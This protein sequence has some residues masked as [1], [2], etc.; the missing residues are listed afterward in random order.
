MAYY[1]I[2]DYDPNKRAIINPRQYGLKGPVPARGVLCC[3][4]DIIA[5]FVEKKALRKI[6][7]FRSELMLHPVYVMKHRG[8]DLFVMHPGVGAPLAAGLFEEILC[9]GVKHV[10]VCGGCGV[11]KPEIAAGYTV[12]VTNAIRDEGTS[13]HYLPPGKAVSAT[14]S[15]VKVLE[16]T[17]KEL[18]IPYIEGTSWTTDGF[19]RETNVRRE[20]RIREGC[21]VVEMEAAA[22]FAVAKFRK[23]KIGQIVYGG[24]VVIPKGW[25]VRDW[26]KRGDVR[27]GLF[28]VAVEACS[29]L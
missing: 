15:V 9:W 1:P 12:V 26:Y 8:V 22:L 21:V 4:Q 13:Y 28:R 3:F 17:L 24:D 25:D 2:L 27:E 14:P 29:R 7:D 18:H 11:L 19:F 20:K 6:G 16:T 23:V 10:I 5:K